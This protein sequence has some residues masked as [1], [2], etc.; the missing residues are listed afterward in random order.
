MNALFSHLS[1]PI[2]I[3]L[4][5]AAVIVVHLLVLILR[6]LSRR[7]MIALP[8][9]SFA[10]VRTIS[11]LLTSIVIFI[12]YFSAVGLVLKEFGVSLTAYLAS[13]SVLGL[14]IGFGS[15]G[16]VQDVVTGLTLIFSDL[17]DIDD[18]VEISGQTGVVETI[19]MR[20]LVLKN[21]LGAQVF[22]P[23][24]TI[25]SVINYRRGYV[26]CLVDITLPGQK[27]VA[28][29]MLL[30][31]TPII[32]SA[33]EQF[34]GIFITQPS[35]EGQFKTLSGKEFFRFKFRIWPGRGSVLE[36]ILKQEIV[37]SLKELDPAYADWMVAV[38]YEVEKKSAVIGA[39]PH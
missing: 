26:R 11:S 19:S 35:P 5:I 13:A 17:V 36:T 38:N 18:M 6:R 9:S 39:K 2:R 23:N 3:L 7:I 20:F 34:P 4:I 32:T 33:F 27:E 24:R 29:Q 25:T 21:H 1:Y 15:Q 14:A 37:Q 31:V 16:L 28:E 30:K 8:R 12:F 22:I 10:K